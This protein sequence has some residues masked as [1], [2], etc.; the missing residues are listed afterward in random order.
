MGLPPEYWWP[1][2]SL[3]EVFRIEFSARTAGD[4]LCLRPADNR[5]AGSADLSI[6]FS[7]ARRA[8]PLLLVLVDPSK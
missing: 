7:A 3:E 4:G 2:N 1:M 8:V 5:L 6:A